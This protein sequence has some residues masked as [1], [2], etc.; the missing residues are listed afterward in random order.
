MKLNKNRMRLTDFQITFE[1]P[2]LKINT[3]TIIK[4]KYLKQVGQDASKK[5]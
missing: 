4:S 5:S 1:N 3:I 2:F